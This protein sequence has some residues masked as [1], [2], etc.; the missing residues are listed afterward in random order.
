MNIR[1][2]LYLLA[3]IPLGGLLAVFL[4]SLF[5]ITGLRQAADEINTTS[6]VRWL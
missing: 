4:V 6:F 2:K 1:N 3:G 5:V